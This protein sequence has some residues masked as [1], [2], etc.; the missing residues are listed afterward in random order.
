MTECLAYIPAHSRTSDGDL[1]DQAA[2]NTAQIIPTTKTTSRTDFLITVKG[3]LADS[4]EEQW[5][6]TPTDMPEDLRIVLISKK[7]QSI[8]KQISL[9]PTNFYH[10][11]TDFATV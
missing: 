5:Q 1:A 6:E 8:F 7:H 11:S 4:W 9:E 10:V 2:K 3:A